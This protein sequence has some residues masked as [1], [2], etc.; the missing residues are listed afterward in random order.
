MLVEPDV[1]DIF[2]RMPGYG[3]VQTFYSQDTR[4]L[5]G[6]NFVHDQIIK[7]SAPS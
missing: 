1:H 5:I 4:Y 7:I 6:K 3:F 2:A